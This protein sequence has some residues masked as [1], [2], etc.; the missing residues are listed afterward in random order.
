MENLGTIKK[1]LD[2]IPSLKAKGIDVFFN[3][4]TENNIFCFDMYWG[5]IKSNG[6]TEQIL[7]SFNKN[8]KTSVKL[9]F[10]KIKEILFE[11]EENENI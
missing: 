8:Y 3:Y 1:F 4:Y 2:Y 9:A 10:G 7:I 11:E 5:G 6:R